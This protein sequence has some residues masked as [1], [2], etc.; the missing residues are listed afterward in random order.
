MITLIV[1]A[2][3]RQGMSQAEFEQYWWEK[4]AP[5]VRSIPEFMRHVRKY[6]LY[7]MAAGQT[8]ANAFASTFFGGLSS[9]DGVGM[10]YF[11]SREAMLEAFS[12]PRYLEMIRPDEPK[13]LDLDGC[14]SFI[15]NEWIVHDA[16][17]K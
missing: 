17:G 8:D 2:R 4:H 1:C 3:R 7:K 5:L 15:A 14:L 16:I 11:D 12:E 9:Y 10:L 13:F 6:V